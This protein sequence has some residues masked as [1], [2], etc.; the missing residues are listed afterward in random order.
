MSSGSLGLGGG[1]AWSKDHDKILAH[2]KQLK[3]DKVPGVTLPSADAPKDEWI[4]AMDK[5]NAWKAGEVRKEDDGKAWW[6]TFAESPS[7]AV[8]ESTGI[9]ELSRT[10]VSDNP[11][12]DNPYYPMLVQDYETP[13]LVD[14]SAYMPSDSPFGYEQYQPYTNPNNIPDNIFYYQPPEIY[15][16]SAAFGGMGLGGTGSA[17]AQYLRPELGIAA[18]G[19]LATNTSNESSKGGDGFPSGTPAGDAS[20]YMIPGT[21]VSAQS[22][23]DYEGGDMSD[24]IYDVDG[25]I[26]KRYYITPDSRADIVRADLQAA[27]DAAYIQAAKPMANLGGQRVTPLSPAQVLNYGGSDTIQ[28]QIRSDIAR[29]QQQIVKQSPNSVVAR[30]IKG[31][32]QGGG[33]DGGGDG[34]DNASGKSNYGQ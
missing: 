24:T 26:S 3:Y 25:N 2:A 15:G 11:R 4:S 31:E 13:S 30:I 29:V 27:R 22:L 7:G 14:Y 6:Q 16:D 18:G 9:P 17:G 5:F 20:D 28:D 34:D 12:P 21:N 33:A 8:V 32:P 23:L 10:S 1:D 19:G